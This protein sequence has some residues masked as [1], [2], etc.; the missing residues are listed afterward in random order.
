MMKIVTKEAAAQMIENGKVIAINGFGPL[1]QPET[2]EVAIKERFEAEQEPRDL[3]LVVAAGQGI[4]DRVS[5]ID[6][7]S[8]DGL[9]T[10]V[11][12]GHYRSMLTLADMGAA[13]KIEAYNIPMGVI[14]QMFRAMAGRKPGLLTKVGL[15]TFCDP[16][17]EGGKLNS[18]SK[19]EMVS[20]YEIDGEE[21]LFYKAFPLDYAL[22]RGTTVDP[23]G[24]ITMEKEAVFLDALSMAQA[25][26]ANGGKVIVQVERCSSMPAKPSEV[27]IPAL[28]VDAVVVEPNQK[29][30][31]FEVF[32]PYYTGD[33]RMPEEHIPEFL[34]KMQDR[35]SIGGKKRSLSHYIITRR[36]AQEVPQ[37]CIANLGGGLPEMVGWFIEKS[38]NCHLT[39]ESG[40]LGGIP[41]N[42]ADFGA[43]IN[44]H[45]IYDQPYQFDFYDGGGLDVT[46]LGALEV[47]H[48]GNVNVSRSGDSIVGVGGFI[49]ITQNTKKAVYCFPFSVKGLQIHYEE[50]KLSIDREGSI[51]KFT[52]EVQQV[53]FSGEY[54]ND[55]GQEVLYITERCVFRLTKAGLHLIE[56][57]PGI[58]L[59]SQILD[60]IPFEISVAE[61]LKVMEARFFADPE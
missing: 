3:T 25:V 20:L 28:L 51:L 50:G 2:L 5:F 39:V 30:T 21:Y 45:V 10:K 1:A 31:H 44:P 58:D 24:N 12:A 11:I 4:Y 47:D 22:I 37:D 38:K 33:I 29:Q 26:K 59:Q 16:R 9:F 55:T 52:P 15:K 19:D 53:S 6:Q 57:A 60:L 46:F 27:K 7:I 14:S 13:E 23:R 61:D 48:E 18:I 42:G 54:A 56:I 35:S 40:V 17:R 43:A 41:T 34:R 32:N 49:N 36:A 8:L